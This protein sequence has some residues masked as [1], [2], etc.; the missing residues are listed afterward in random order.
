[1]VPS[2]PTLRQFLLSPAAFFE[3]RPPAETLPIAAGIVVLFAV[4]L[5]VSLVLIG[6]MLAGAVDAT[7]TMDNPD[8]PPG[9]ICDHHEGASDSILSENCD[10]PETI[11]RDAG[12]LVQE[13][14]HDYLWIALIG[15]FVLW[16][17]GGV[18]LYAAGRLAGGTPSFTGTLA[19]AGWAA[20]PE[21]F[22]LAVGV[23]AIRVALSS[24]TIT[25]LDKAADALEAAM[26]PIDPVL[27]VASLVT[28]AWQWHVLTG[29]LSR[30]AALSRRAAAVAAGVP[31]ALY[32]LV[33]VA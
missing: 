13:A 1:M 10:E 16:L 9:P 22:R 31:L 17:G 11:E 27:L 26:A 29:G 14:I 30:E 6:S 19:L 24:L 20:L 25:D 5:V 23:V 28:V 3:E 33:T 18:V 15:P 12:A 8:R 7:V 4:S 32:A 21:L 2:V